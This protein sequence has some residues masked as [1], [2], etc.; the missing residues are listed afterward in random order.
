MVRLT[1]MPR[2]RVIRLTDSL[3]MTTVVNLDVKE[4]SSKNIPA[5]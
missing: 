2:K 1:D 5:S 3:D 4:Y